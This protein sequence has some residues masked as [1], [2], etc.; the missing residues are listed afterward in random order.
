MKSE[1]QIFFIFLIIK[2]EFVLK[3]FLFDLIRAVLFGVLFYPYRRLSG[4]CESIKKLN[5]GKHTF[6]SMRFGEEIKN[7]VTMIIKVK[8]QGIPGI[9]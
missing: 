1:G 8:T 7:R 4:T 9:D 5:S 6:L 2:N 3:I